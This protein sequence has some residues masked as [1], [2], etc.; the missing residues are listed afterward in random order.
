MSQ[1][2][3]NDGNWRRIDVADAPVSA[4]VIERMID[5]YWQDARPRSDCRGCM[6][7]A[8]HVLLD[9]VCGPVTVDELIAA[10]CATPPTS[11][12]TPV[13]NHIIAARRAR[14]EQ[15]KPPSERVTVQDRGH[16]WD[17]YLDGREHAVFGAASGYSRENAEI[18]AD[19]LRARLEREK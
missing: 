17:V 10:N 9:A 18:Y 3:H 8:A 11:G 2:I 5:A 1:S 6:T 12:M 15:P 19:G 7:A 4:D 16:A 14:I 13:I